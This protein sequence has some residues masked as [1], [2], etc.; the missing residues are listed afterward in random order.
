MLRTAGALFSAGRVRHAVLEYTPAQFEGRGTDYAEMLPLLYA[1]GA[2]TCF[3][4]HR[5]RPLH[6]RIPREATRRFYEVNKRICMQTDIYCT[7][8]SENPFR[9]APIW[10][11]H[12]DLTEGIVAP[13]YLS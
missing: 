1:L 12:T 11:E 7:F 4:A 8:C 9:G 13:L 6:Y 2:R 3:A 10:T 5:R